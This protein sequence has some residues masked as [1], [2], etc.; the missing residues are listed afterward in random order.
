MGMDKQKKSSKSTKWIIF[1]FAFLLTILASYAAVT[2]Y[3]DPL[4][5]YHAPLP[6]YQYPIEDQRYQND[7]ILRHFEYNAIITGTSLTQ[8]FKVSE[9]NELFGVEF[10]KVPLSGA[11]YKEIGDQLERAFTYGKD[12]KLVIRALDLTSLILD[13]D[14][15]RD[16]YNPPEYLYNNNLLDDTN[17]IF[18]KTLFSRNI[19]V[20]DFTAAGNQTT[21]FDEYGYTDGDPEGGADVVLSTYT[22]NDRIAQRHLTDKEKEIIADNLRQNI[23]ELV[24][25]YPDTAFYYFFPPYSIAYWDEL[26]S[27]GELDC[28]LEAIEFATDE[29]LKHP[30]I[31][32]FNFC[33]DYDTV[34]NL[35]NY[36]DQAHYRGEICSVLLEY[37]AEGIYYINND[38][39]CDT[40]VNLSRFYKG[41]DYEALHK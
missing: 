39:Y 24:D 12:I 25:R 6:Q 4:F 31:K 16:N 5:H 14:A 38:N 32:L 35:D 7:G 13:K 26:D 37:L 40:A 3:I 36:K 19:K 22:I 27:L 1:T 2:I 34:C 11:R 41:F 33:L 20:L 18:N 17:Y 8:K 10:V 30:N 15:I 29:L 9:A 28:M 23:T 21:S